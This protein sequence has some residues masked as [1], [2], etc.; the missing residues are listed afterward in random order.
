MHISAKVSKN[1]SLER[2]DLN[3]QVVIFPLFSG[4]GILQS[5]DL[6]SPLL[7]DHYGLQ[8]VAIRLKNLD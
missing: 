6:H 5:C 2:F 8:E 1:D 3:H 4:K 7:R